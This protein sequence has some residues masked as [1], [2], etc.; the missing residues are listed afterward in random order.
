VKGSR[1]NVILLEG[2]HAQRRHAAAQRNSSV[3][4]G[5]NPIRPSASEKLGD[6]SPE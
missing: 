4:C 2:L 5:D 3:T 6:R 1:S